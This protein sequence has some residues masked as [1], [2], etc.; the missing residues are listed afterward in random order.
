MNQRIL[1]FTLAFA[2]MGA[3]AEVHGQAYQPHLAYQPYFALGRAPPVLL[4]TEGCFFGWR[5]DPLGVCW[6]DPDAGFSSGNCWYGSTPYG[7]R[8]VC[9]WW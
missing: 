6:P 7:H 4:M 8:R 2:L 9:R 3:V 1:Q 5:R